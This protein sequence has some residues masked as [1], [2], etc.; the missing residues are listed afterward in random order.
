MICEVFA[1]IADSDLIE[2]SLKKC[3]KWSTLMSGNEPLDEKPNSS[4]E[5]YDLIV[6]GSGPAGVHAAVQA[7]KLNKKVCVIEKMP[8]KIGG[9]WIHTGT[10]PSK[11]LRESLATIHSIRNH[12]G[13]MWVDRIIEGLNT[14]RLLGRA[15]KVSLQEEALVRKHIDNNNIKLIEG[16][17]V[18]ENRFS[19]RV[20]AP[21][22]ES[23]TVDGHYILVAT[24][25][26][27]RRP[28]NI[29]FDGWRIVDSDEILTL[30]HIP[31]SMVVYG[32]GVVGCEYACIFSAI[33]VDVTVID[34]RS[35]ILQ[36]LDSEVGTELQRSMED[37]NVKFILG[38]TLDHIQVKGPRVFTTAGKHTLDTDLLFYAAGRVSSTERMGLERLGITKN[39][40]GAVIVNE[41][42]QTSVSN[43]YAAGDAIG[44]PALAA[45]SYHQGR[46]VSCHAFGIPIAPFPKQF[47]VGVYTIPELSM[48]GKTEEEL[49][50]EGVDYVVGRATYGEIARGYIRGDAHG[51]LKL[52]ICTKTH[53]ILGI[54]IVGDD[55][56]NLIHIGLAFMLKGGC[57]QDF[58]DMIFNYPT[59]AEGYKIAAFNALNKI[60]ENGVILPPA[61]DEEF[62]K[63]I[64]KSASSQT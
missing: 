42:F 12:V 7:A 39:D 1:F 37:L 58:I 43:I 52:I 59:L 64:K 57:A 48:V 33:G 32:A 53:K 47:P 14:G 24:G 27:P 25:S 62:V 28:N 11:T 20:I 9:C 5:V 21:D 40:R 15:T 22:K 55:A 30:E 45:T 18:L 44:P 10:L 19:V 60:F 56:C 36:Y 2:L 49:K 35:R 50:K 51:L 13:E 41:K 6:I 46:Y 38:E 16:Y 8:N 63:P 61:L 34:S 29:P 3:V 26:K 31:K 23:F 54:H 17:G 4:K